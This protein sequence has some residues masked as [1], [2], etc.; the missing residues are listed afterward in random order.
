MINDM[1][2]GKPFG[3]ILKMSIPIMM[4]NLFQ[5]FYSMAD[6]VIVGRFLGENALAAVGSTSS[7]YNLILW[8]VTGTASGFTILVA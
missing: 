8:F 3:M 1:T 5:Q 6:A 2:T 7:L 4:G